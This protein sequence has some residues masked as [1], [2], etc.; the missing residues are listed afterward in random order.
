MVILLKIL[1]FLP[2]AIWRFIMKPLF[3]NWWQKIWRQH[4]ERAVRNEDITI[5]AMSPSPLRLSWTINNGS[6]ARID[7]ERVCGS[8]FMSDW[9]IVD[10]DVH[11]PNIHKV[12]AANRHESLTVQATSLRKGDKSCVQI[13][14]YP[15]LDFWLSDI[16]NNFLINGF[17]VVRGYAVDAVIPVIKLGL[18]VEG[19][20]EAVTK[21]RGKLHD[22]LK[23]KLGEIK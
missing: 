20:S 9:R 14:F 19:L 13:A 10:F 2:E 16:S 1:G 11:S 22:S 23:D 5:W 3:Y 4:F 17:I 21:Y 15:P 8:V 6:E 12:E 7:I 18:K